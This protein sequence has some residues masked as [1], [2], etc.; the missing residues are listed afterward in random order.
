[1]TVA[2]SPNWVLAIVVLLLSLFLFLDLSRLPDSADAQEY[3]F[4][5]LTSC[6]E[7]HICNLCGNVLEVVD[8]VQRSLLDP[9]TETLTLS[10]PE[11][12]PHSLRSYQRCLR[13]PVRRGCDTLMNKIRSQRF[14]FSKMILQHV[15]KDN[16]FQRKWGSL[17]EDYVLSNAIWLTN[18][19]F[20]A[21][22]RSLRERLNPYNEDGATRRIIY[23]PSTLSLSSDPAMESLMTSV[24]FLRRDLQQSHRDFCYSV[25]EGKLSSLGRVRLSF[26]RFYLHNSIKPKLLQLQRNHWGTFIV[27]ELMMIGVAICVERMMR[28]VPPWGE[29]ILTTVDGRRLPAGMDTGSGVVG[30][31]P[32]ATTRGGDG[33]G[34]N[35]S[36]YPSARGAAAPGGVRGHCRQG[37]RR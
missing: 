25:C 32:S 33:G 18:Y 13:D 12:D 10:A 31:S 26:A 9:F 36:P 27:I 4:A 20:D 34:A 16:Y 14:E 35:H 1:M 21:Q 29:A 24:W 5:T 37:R 22:E 3:I 11:W 8:V 28:P 15:L 30:R 7:Q 6:K 17:G 19:I 23:H 2:L